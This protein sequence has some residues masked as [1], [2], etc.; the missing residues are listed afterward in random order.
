[1]GLTVGS[2]EVLRRSLHPESR[3]R[4]PVEVMEGAA[5]GLAG[6]VVH[7]QRAGVAAGHGGHPP[8]IPVAGAAAQQQ[9]KAWLGQCLAEPAHLPVPGDARVGQP[10]AGPWPS[11]WRRSAVLDGGAVP[12]ADAELGDRAKAVRQPGTKA[13]RQR[14]HSRDQSCAEGADQ[15]TG[16][17]RHRECPIGEPHHEPPDRAALGVVG[18]QQGRIGHTAADQGELPA[19]VPGILDTGV[20]ALGAGRAVDVGGIAGQEDAAVPVAAGVAVLQ[21]EV[22]QPDGIA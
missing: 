20:H 7:G 19:Q 9:M 12:V 8:G 22:G 3:E 18:I 6:Q 14:Q 10:V 21:P 11:S 16:R 4:L 17:G 15:R 1:M 5:R 13:E 2:D